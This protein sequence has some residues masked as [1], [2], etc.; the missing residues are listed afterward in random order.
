[1][2]KLDLKLTTISKKMLVHLNAIY[3]NFLCFIN[4]V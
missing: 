4:K 1:M 3:F 2:D